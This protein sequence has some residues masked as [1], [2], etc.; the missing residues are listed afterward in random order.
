MGGGSEWRKA[1]VLLTMP[2]FFGQSMAGAGPLDEGTRSHDDASML[3]QVSQAVLADDPYEDEARVVPGLMAPG[4]QDEA[5]AVDQKLI[6]AQLN[7]VKA[8]Q[9]QLEALCSYAA[10]TNAG[11]ACFLEQL[12]ESCDRKRE[13]LRAQYETLRAIRGD[14][15]K[16]TTRFF[17]TVNRVRREIWSGLGPLGRNIVRNL[18]KDVVSVVTSQGQITGQVFRVLLRKHVRHELQT[19][20]LSRLARRDG[21]ATT[22]SRACEEKTPSDAAADAPQAPLR[23]AQ[24]FHLPSQGIWQLACDE[25]DPF[26]IADMRTNTWELVVDFGSRTFWGNI[27]RTVYDSVL[28]DTSVWAERVTGEVTEDGYLRGTGTWKS[29]MREDPIAWTGAI[30]VDLSHVCIARTLQVD[31]W[32]T[33]DWIRQNGREMFMT[34][35]GACT[36]LCIVSP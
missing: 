14:R 26:M 33:P 18:T 9:A 3:A 2:A 4:T 13:R 12:K 5:P 34:P 6:E 32:L 29:G 25:Q 10:K 31:L 19:A 1:V 16:A 30:A 20:A 7:A 15:R 36:G 24:T 8:E 22:S 35:G 11:D 21:T 28:R 23:E 17:A 27:D